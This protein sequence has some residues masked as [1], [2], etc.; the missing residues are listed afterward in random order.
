MVRCFL[1]RGVIAL[2]QI[3]DGRS[4]T[5]LQGHLSGELLLFVIFD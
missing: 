1:P 5:W 4:G 3:P 2:R